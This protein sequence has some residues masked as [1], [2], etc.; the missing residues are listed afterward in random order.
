MAFFSSPLQ[1]EAVWAVASLFG[2]VR[3]RVVTLFDRKC[4]YCGKTVY[5][6]EKSG[7]KQLFFGCATTGAP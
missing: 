3:A 4:V 1:F 2:R 6:A 5:F 7:K